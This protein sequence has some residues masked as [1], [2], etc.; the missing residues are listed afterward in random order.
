MHA[1][2]ERR[3]H[4]PTDRPSEP[5]HGLHGTFR[6]V[7]PP[8][9]RLRT[10]LIGPATGLI[11]HVLLLALLGG[12]VGLDAAGWVVGV[13]CGAIVD[14]ALAVGL[15]RSGSERLGPAGWVTLTR[16]TLAVGVAA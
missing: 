16:A 9:G 14:T 11:G 15:L 12:T 8:G 1:I 10:V 13:A 6:R 3:S 4:L 2:D 5:D 7:F